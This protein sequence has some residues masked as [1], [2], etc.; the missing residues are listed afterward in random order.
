MATLTIRNL[1]DDL[2][3]RIK[4]RA[5]ANEHSMEQEVRQLLETRYASH[6]MVIDRICER[7]STLPNTTP[8]E[9]DQW[10]EIGRQSGVGE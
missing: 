5:A 4:T 1:P 3:Q 8:E 6:K 10:R 7:W 9:I 2:V